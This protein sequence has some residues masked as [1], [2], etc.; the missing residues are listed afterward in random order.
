MSTTIRI[1]PQ[2]FQPDFSLMFSLNTVS[3]KGAE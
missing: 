3:M 2:G 1:A